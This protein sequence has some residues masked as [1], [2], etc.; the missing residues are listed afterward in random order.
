MKPKKMGPDQLVELLS[1]V[2]RC[3]PRDMDTDVAQGWINNQ[4]A[5]TKVLA[6]ALMSP[7]VGGESKPIAPIV[8][9][10]DFFIP[11]KDAG[12]P[13]EHQPT[14]AKYRL[15][16]TSCG[17]P[18]TTAV[19]YTVRAGFTL[20]QHAPKFGPCE[21][22]FS[23]LQD[24]NFNDEPTKDS[25]VFWIPRLVPGSTSKSKDA[26]M[27]LLGEI[28]ARN[29]LPAHHLTSLVAGLILVHYKTTGE[30][31]PLDRL[32]VR[33]DTCC[34][35]G[36]RLCLGRFGESGLDCGRWSFDGYASDYVGVFALGV[37]TLGH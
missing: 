14:L 12:V 25:L 32:W 15:L 8:P 3:V 37:E 28:R 35:D 2:V 36:C 26:Q 22:G 24:W 13:A 19:C 27:R 5:L 16:A 30:R 7:E 31:V 6:V 11:L 34:A 10:P 23:Y 18:T 4:L 33:T 1:A 29:E 21:K 20:K 9:E 17:V